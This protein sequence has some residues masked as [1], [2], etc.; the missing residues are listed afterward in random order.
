MFLLTHTIFKVMDVLEYLDDGDYF[1]TD[2]ENEAEDDFVQLA[3][4][5]A[6]SRQ[7]KMIRK[8]PDHFQI[9]RDDEF[10]HRFRLKKDT[11]KFILYM[12]ESKITSQTT[13]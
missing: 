5:V 12:I 10:L 8:Q 4:F 9:W 7:K 3:E 6:F 13:R 11:V 1:D 2:D